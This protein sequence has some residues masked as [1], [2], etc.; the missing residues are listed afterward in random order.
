MACSPALPIGRRLPAAGV[1]LLHPGAAL[2]GRSPGQAPIPVGGVPWQYGGCPSFCTFSTVS[3]TSPF[4]P[5]ITVG[6]TANHGP[7]RWADSPAPRLIV[8]FRFQTTPVKN[9]PDGRSYASPSGKLGLCRL[10][11]LQ[12]RRLGTA[13]SRRC[14]FALGD[15]QWISCPIA[16]R[17]L[18][19]LPSL[20]IMM[21]HRCHGLLAQDI[22]LIGLH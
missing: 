14:A 2:I 7:S 6:L 12:R 18:P 16:A 9:P 10:G 11:I 13:G 21:V 1:A 22:I 20:L 15:P 5:S 3:T 8:I 17:F 19:V 4:L